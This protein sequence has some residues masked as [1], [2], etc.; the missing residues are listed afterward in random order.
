MHND[1]DR[2]RIQLKNGREK[3]VARRSC[4]FFKLNSNVFFQLWNF[5]ISHSNHTAT[6]YRIVSIWKKDANQKPLLELIKCVDTVIG[7]F[8]MEHLVYNSPIIIRQRCN[9][10][11]AA[12]HSIDLSKIFGPMVHDSF[13]HLSKNLPQSFSFRSSCYF[14]ISPEFTVLLANRNAKADESYGIKLD[15]SH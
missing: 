3:L 13:E 10:K 9:F 15:R 11:S 5:S 4:C 2:S 12:I 6:K 14:W 7:Q 1:G 8:D